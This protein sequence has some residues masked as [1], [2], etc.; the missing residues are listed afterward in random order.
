MLS[1]AHDRADS[2]VRKTHRIA[3]EARH[4]EGYQ[5]IIYDPSLKLEEIRRELYTEQRDWFDIDGQLFALN[6]NGSIIDIKGNESDS[7]GVSVLPDGVSIA[8]LISAKQKYIDEN[9]SH[10]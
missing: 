5:R 7:H 10:D 1:K 8:D 2:I 3:R 9:G 6:E 4:D